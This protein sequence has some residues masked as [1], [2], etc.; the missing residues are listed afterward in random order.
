MPLSCPGRLVLVVTAS[1]L[2][3]IGA[4]AADDPKA[5]APKQIG[6]WEGS[7]RAIAPTKV[8]DGA[9]ITLPGA[10]RQTCMGGNG[11]FICF[12]TP[13]EKSVTVLDVCEG[14]TKQIAL[15]EEDARIAAGNTSLFIYT[16]KANTIERWSL[17]TF[18]KEETAAYPLKD[19]PLQLL[20]GH[21]SNGPLYVIGPNVALD[22]KTF[23]EVDL[24]A[25][26]PP[27]GPNGKPKTWMEQ[28][29]K[30]PTHIR[31]SADGR[32]LAS[33]WETLVVGSTD[34][35]V[36]QHRGGAFGAVQP[37]PDGTLF[38]YSGL[39]APDFKSIEFKSN[40]QWSHLL[41]PGAHGPMY[42]SLQTSAAWNP[43]GKRP[44]RRVFL[45]LL[46]DAQPLVALGTGVEL[47]LP[48]NYAAPGVLHPFGRLFLVPEA[49]AL[50][51]LNKAAT[52]VR[53]WRADLDELLAGTEADYLV[54]TSRPP[55]VVPGKTFTYKPTVKAKRDRLKFSFEAAPEGMKVSPDGT[56]TWDVP[57]GWTGPTTVTFVVTD[58]T[59]QEV[60][61]TFTVVKAL[62]GSD[63][64]KAVAV[65]AGSNPN[66]NSRVV[67]VN[68][69]RFS[70]PPVT[71]LEIKTAPLDHNKV[72]LKL[73]GLVFDAVV[74]GGGRYWCLHLATQRQVA[75]FDVNEAKIT[76]TVPLAS[77]NAV[78]AAGMNKLFVA[79]PDVG[80][81][82]R[83]DLATLQKEV[84]TKLPFDGR[85]L[86]MAMGS[87]SSGPIL[88]RY[89]VDGKQDNMP[90]VFLDGSTFQLLEV[91]YNPYGYPRPGYGH[92]WSY[93]ATPDGRNFVSWGR[94]T[95]VIVKRET[96]TVAD[97]GIQLGGGEEM[98][99]PSDGNVFL[100]RDRVTTNGTARVAS[101]RGD[102]FR[103][104]SQSGPFYLAKSSGRLEGNPD[105][106]IELYG[107]WDERPLAA[108]KGI[109]LSGGRTVAAISENF[110]Y[111]ARHF[112][113]PNGGV[114]GVL[115]APYDK[116]VLYKLDM[117]ALL[118]KSES[119]Y[120][121]V[122]NRPPA[123]EAGKPFVYPVAV[124]SKQGGV[125]FKLDTGP[126]G[127]KIAPEG[128]LTWD[129]PKDWAEP[130]GVVLRIGDKSGAELF[131]SFV[132]A[133]Y[134]PGALAIAQPPVKPVPPK[135]G[136][137]VQLENPPGG[138]KVD[139]VRP[140]ANPAKIT[141]TKVIEPIELKLPNTAN[142]TCLGGNGRY[143]IF[144]LPKSKVAAILDVCEGKFV[145]NVPIQEEGTLIAAGN[146]HL[147]LVSPKANVIVRWNLVTLQKEA[148]YPNPYDTEP[149]DAILG[150]ACD[151][152]LLLIGP[153]K[154]GDPGF[155]LNALPQPS[156]RVGKGGIG[157]V[158]GKT[159][160]AIEW[161]AGASGG[162]ASPAWSRGYRLPVRVSADG[163]VYGVWATDRGN[164]QSVVFGPEGA[165]TY[166]LDTSVAPLLPFPD[167]TLAWRRGLYTS[168]LK[169]LRDTS[170]LRGEPIPAAHGR[171]YL[172]FQ[173]P[174]SRINQPEPSKKEVHVRLLGEERPLGDLNAL[175]GL[176]IPNDPDY[177]FKISTKLMPWERLFLVPDAKALVAL[178]E[179]CE[180]V[181]IHRVDPDELLAKAKFDYLLVTSQ[182][183]GAVR[184]GTF[185]YKP[186][187]TAKQ[188]GVKITLDSGPQ[189]MKLT[190]G[191]LTW[192]VPTDFAG[193]SVFV[194]LTITDAA[195]QEM[196]HTFSL[197]IRA[198][199]MNP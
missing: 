107:Y 71:P 27:F 144:R 169:P 51:A 166:T 133:P 155:V 5:D 44:A 165:K 64:G 143:V 87:A 112:F 56:I 105:G 178:D 10:V 190:D 98:V 9:E 173:T 132:L 146:E 13:K 35:K 89:S 8:A 131:H 32:V 118:G 182:P 145:K 150:H 148:T 39:Y 52:A 37:G 68:R 199:P 149:H 20:M 97:S 116:L 75:I 6:P 69:P 147:Y 188:G 128:T 168:D 15:P 136:P 197:P 180:K 139:V 110:E 96:F 42:L 29:P 36:N 43:G 11:R 152:P 181:T 111:D 163:R 79:Y 62:P 53:V 100:G 1:L 174:G 95:G 101:P 48:D 81:I 22:P 2:A 184:G 171:L 88:I 195:G 80:V 172:A 46:G 40:R 72:E 66:A 102:Y 138:P 73:P 193:D 78:V 91:G 122:N 154:D 58:P 158:D 164:P 161:P 134:V 74:G 41:I 50:V 34:S 115:P 160:K 117:E 77:G 70:F 177:P 57:K 55:Q 59:R 103:I 25:E 119:N 157:L 60:P 153:G 54:V 196:L 191:T 21:G 65:Q 120:L 86:N 124:K 90:V 186:A 47:E 187:V 99:L 123:A 183:P 82:V 114:F 108:L 26:L 137:P 63:G 92:W 176:G 175:T 38:T 18:Q 19:P 170:S 67:P 109:E 85:V 198:K 179:A 61:H 93:R 104:P 23:K 83:Y 142:A 189:G 4:L 7:P 106:P 17:T 162:L 140:A 3:A 156:I 30:N 192:G 127:M 94:G 45:Q 159:G 76:K 141:P 129:V 31:I 113:C 135:L 167:G 151:G 126:E 24:R 130:V 121:F 84:A 125:T 16:P 33:P 28:N 14:Q 49:R 194:I 185:T 12:H